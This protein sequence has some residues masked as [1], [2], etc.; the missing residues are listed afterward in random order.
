MTSKNN[1]S[2]SL[3]DRLNLMFWTTLLRGILAA[4]LGVLLLFQPEKTTPFLISFMGMFWLLSGLLSIRWATSERKVKPLSL[5]AGVIAVVA[6]LSA[7]LNRFRPF[8]Y[9]LD[10]VLIITI[11]GSLLILTGLM[12][13]VGGF[14]I[15]EREER[16]RTV[17]SVLLG[18]FETFM[19]L[20]LIIKP[21]ERGQLI[22][23][24]AA[25]WA[26]LGGFILL[27]DALLLRK[28]SRLSLVQ[29]DEGEINQE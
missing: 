22:Y 20:L 2:Q 17:A 18:V 13:I 23:Y 9:A 16:T 1:K 7:L 14:R 10:E 4:L 6:G 15:G 29:A 5:I 8:G 27:G 11:L 21:L 19:G 26:L 25:I 12:H 28:S 3:T 24:L